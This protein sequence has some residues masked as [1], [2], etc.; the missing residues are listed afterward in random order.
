MIGKRVSADTT[1]ED[2]FVVSIL[3]QGTEVEH[4]EVRSVASCQE[5]LHVS[6]VIAIDAF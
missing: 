1:L 6:A 2:A 4:P 5:A 3:S